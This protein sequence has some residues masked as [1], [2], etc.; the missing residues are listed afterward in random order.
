[1]KLFISSLGNS[2]STV[3]PP[4]LEAEATAPTIDVF[5]PT[6]NIVGC[7]NPLA[8]NYNPFA[9]VSDGSCV[10][11]SAVME[12][13]DVVYIPLIGH[14]QIAG[15]GWTNA[16]G[17]PTGDYLQDA[18]KI[19]NDMQYANGAS[20]FVLYNPATLGIDH[21]RE[22]YLNLNWKDY[23]DATNGEPLYTS[24]HV[25]VGAARFSQL[26]IGGRYFEQALNQIRPKINNLVASGKKVTMYFIFDMWADDSI[27]GS[28]PMYDVYHSHWCLARALG[29]Q[30]INANLTTSANM[31]S[32]Y[33]FMNN[34]FIEYAEAD[35]TRR[36]TAVASP[37]TPTVDGAHWS[38]FALRDFALEH[39]A[40]IEFQPKMKI[41]WTIPAISGLTMAFKEVP[42]QRGLGFS[43]EWDVPCEC[44]VFT[45]TELLYEKEISIFSID[46]RLMRYG[47]VT[48]IG[49]LTGMTRFVA[50][51]TGT[52]VEFELVDKF[53]STLNFIDLRGN[54]LIA[55]NPA[56]IV[57]YSNDYN[58]MK[59][60]QGSVSNGTLKIAGSVNG[61][62]AASASHYSTLISRGWTIDVPSP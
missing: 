23:I 29:L 45:D 54:A 10:L 20:S 3:V 9:T 24:K 57:S 22:A 31:V 26:M 56:F 1:M 33:P 44:R 36:S 48:L 43:V 39:L 38:S 27:Y 53:V 60:A 51:Y 58:V 8:I 14:S 18:D 41:N 11:E 19:L 52:C 21:G 62:T 42:N 50:P 7:M 16:P 4:P 35:P 37:S 12:E 30:Q 17:V 34:S 59:L 46:I 61:L 32:W 2:N 25:L 15:K 47:F 49:D 55:G 40:A 6:E 5:N 28:R 13:D